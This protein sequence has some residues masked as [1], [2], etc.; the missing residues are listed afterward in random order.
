MRIS[1]ESLET[2][3][4]KQLGQEAIQQLQAQDFAGLAQRFGYAVAFGRDLATAI[5]EDLALAPVAVGLLDQDIDPVGTISVTFLT[6]NAT[7]LVATIECIA[8]DA[9]SVFTLELIITGTENAFDVT[10]EGVMRVCAG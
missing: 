6:P 8:R 5:R 1:V 3:A 10:L 4:L 2:Q 7:G 9:V